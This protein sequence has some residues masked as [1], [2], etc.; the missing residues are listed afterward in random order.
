MLTQ[1]VPCAG[2]LYEKQTSDDAK[3]SRDHTAAAYYY[4]IVKYS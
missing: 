2:I 4:R 3:E 1:I